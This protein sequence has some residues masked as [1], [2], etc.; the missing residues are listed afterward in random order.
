MELLR[1]NL[2]GV[3]RG[4]RTLCRK[5]DLEIDRLVVNT[6]MMER[7]IQYLEAKVESRKAIGRKAVK[8]DP[9][10]TLLLLKISRRL[11]RRPRG[12]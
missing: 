9:K 4:F 10:Q 5:A 7:R 12:R 1:T 3:D 6:V 2:S 11:E 8:I